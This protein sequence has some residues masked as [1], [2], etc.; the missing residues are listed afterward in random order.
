MGLNLPRVAS[1]VRW[2]RL[3]TSRSLR[4][5]ATSCSTVWIGESRLLVAWAKKAA[6]ASG[7]ARRP[8]LLSASGTLP[9]GWVIVVLEVVGDDVAIEDVARQRDLDR[10]GTGAGAALLLAELGQGTGIVETARE[11]LGDGVDEDRLAI[12]IEQAVGEGGGVAQAAAGVDPARV[13]RVDA[14]D[15]GAQAVAAL[16]LPGGAL[17]AQDLGA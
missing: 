3:R 12:Q 9:L 15:Q 6:S 17:E 14:G 7:A 16:E 4:S 13:E 5:R 2:A 10:N 8:K 1:R 11:D